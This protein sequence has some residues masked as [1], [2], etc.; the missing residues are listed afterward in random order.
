MRVRL[1]EQLNDEGRLLLQA[2][3]R[4]S[5][6]TN[7][8]PLE[9]IAYFKKLYKNDPMLSALL[10]MLEEHFKTGN[11]GA[12]MHKMIADGYGAYYELLYFMLKESVDITPLLR[13]TLISTPPQYSAVICSM[14]CMTQ[15][16]LTTLTNRPRRR[17]FCPPSAFLKQ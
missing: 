6:E 8:N 14:T 10:N 16:Q 12:L 9:E 15:P 11:A 2:F 7:E 1:Y 5:I 3:V 17:R 13:D 4:S